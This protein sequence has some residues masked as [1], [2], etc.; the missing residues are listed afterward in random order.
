MSNYK[1]GANN[2]S[3]SPSRST[4][5]LA[6]LANQSAQFFDQDEVFKLKK[7]FRMKENEYET[8]I[9]LNE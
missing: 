3:V 1:R 7:E 5:G 9:A 6:P 2:S 8:K 4:M